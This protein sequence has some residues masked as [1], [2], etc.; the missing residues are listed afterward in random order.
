MEGTRTGGTTF[1][2]SL[3]IPDHRLGHE[4]ISIEMYFTDEEIQRKNDQ[5]HQLFLTSQFNETSGKA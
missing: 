3:P 1:S 4:N 5:G 2:F